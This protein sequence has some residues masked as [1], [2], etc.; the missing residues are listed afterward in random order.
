MPGLSDY[1]ARFPGRVVHSKTY[2][3]PKA[4]AGKRVLVI[5][6]SASGHDVTDQLLRSGLASRPLYQS[7]RSA[8][9]WDGDAPPAGLVWKPVIAA[10]AADG[11]IVFA[12]GS[13]LGPDAVDVVVY[14]T[15]YKASFPFWNVQANGRPLFDYHDNRFVGTFHHTFV[16]DFPSLAIIGLPRTLTFRSFEYQAIAVARVW[17]GR[18]QLPPEDEQRRWETERAAQRK[19][20]D[21]NFH[22]VEWDSGETD[23]Y[24]G[25]LFRLAGL[26]QLDGRG[27]TPPVLDAKT[28]WAIDNI[29]KYPL[30]GPKDDSKQS[31]SPVSEHGWVVIG[32]KKDS[33]TFL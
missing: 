9:R 28:R 16:H 18:A 20:E 15:G 26:P 11:T 23:A 30:K 4:F 5:G 25:F 32:R 6:N 1:L 8:S 14:A 24:L 19:A 17:A 27:R 10:Y 2:R 21:R 13:T 31:S 29:R 22:D 12:D 3:S 7:R 33:L